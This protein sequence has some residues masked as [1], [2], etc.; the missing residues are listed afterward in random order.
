MCAIPCGVAC[1][2]VQVFL[3]QP[4]FESI[5][6]FIVWV[7]LDIYFISPSHFISPILICKIRIIS[8]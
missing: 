2:G 5:L 1:C 6:L 3:K 7:L 8:K 4:R